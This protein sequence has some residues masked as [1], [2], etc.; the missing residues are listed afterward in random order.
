M[1]AAAAVAYYFTQVPGML[2]ED[3][4]EKAEPEQQRIREAM[5]PVYR[6]LSAKTFGTDSRSIE[7]AKNPDQFVRAIDRTTATELR[8]L[9]PAQKAIARAKRVLSKADE[10][11]LLDTP[12]W[13]LLGGRGDLQEAEEIADREREYLPQA[14]AFL[15]HYER[16][17]SYTRNDI[18]FVRTYGVT[19]G[20][21]FGAIPDSP[22]SPGQVTGPI[23]RTARRLEAQLRGYRKVKAPPE[24][25]R[26]HKTHVALVRYVIA[27]IRELS[28]AV[29]AR[30]LGR[31]NRWERNFAR[32]TKRFRVRVTVRKFVTSSSYAKSVRKLRDV[33]RALVRAYKRLA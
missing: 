18:R 24:L 7:R 21:G 32:G 4:K 9:V 25:R 5:R 26:D 28:S 12:A 8:Q 19:F 6:S 1:L 10:H 23:D 3:Y 2:A 11:A 15:K 22:T 13:P 14:R 17:V 20:K 31:I 27:Q 29:K 30:D 16:V 33:E